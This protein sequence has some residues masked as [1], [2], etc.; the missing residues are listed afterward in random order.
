MQGDLSS[1]RHQEIAVLTEASADNKSVK[2]RSR[3]SV[4]VL[5][6]NVD[7]FQFAFSFGCFDAFLYHTMKE[8]SM[9]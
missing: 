2:Y 6:R 9:T 8:T 7:L 3:Y 4:D 1:R 5:W